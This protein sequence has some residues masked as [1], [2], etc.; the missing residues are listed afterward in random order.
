MRWEGHNR[1][2]SSLNQRTN[3]GRCGWDDI[4]QTNSACKNLAKRKKNPMAN[5]TCNL[6]SYGAEKREQAGRHVG[7]QTIQL[8]SSSLKGGSE[9]PH[10]TDNSRDPG[11][12]KTHASTLP[13][14]RKKRFGTRRQG[15]NRPGGDTEEGNAQAA[16][17]DY[18]LRTQKGKK[19]ITT[20]LK[21][22]TSPLS[23]L[24][25]KGQGEKNASDMNQGSI[26][27]AQ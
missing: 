22:S 21:G 26:I 5:G 20:D 19:K 25:T 9:Q 18:I 6:N 13:T 15:P 24:W 8:G 7:K 4:R 1:I 12:R 16:L 17:R 14:E 27:L 11:G 10:W 23:S 2:V 3:G